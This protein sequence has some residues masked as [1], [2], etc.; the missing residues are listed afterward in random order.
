MVGLLASEP[1][2]TQLLQLPAIPLVERLR[3]R[4]LIAVASRLIGR[5]MLGVM[6]A[7]AFTPGACCPR[8]RW[9]RPSSSCSPD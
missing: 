9:P 7:T 3:R 4:K 8:R 2:L 1:L 5:A 6:A